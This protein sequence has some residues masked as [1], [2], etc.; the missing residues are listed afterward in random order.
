MEVPVPTAAEFSRFL[1]RS[2]EDSMAKGYSTWP[3]SQERA[4]VLRLREEPDVE[5]VPGIRPS[6]VSLTG[7]R[8]T[9]FP[10]NQKRKADGSADRGGRGGRGNGHGRGRGRGG[11]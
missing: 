6:A 4:L 1:R 5:V 7:A 8:F 9:F 11:F 10:Q 3:F 2:V